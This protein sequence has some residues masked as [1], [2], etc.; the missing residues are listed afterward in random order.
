[1][2][3]DSWLIATWSGMRRV[4]GGGERGEEGLDGIRSGQEADVK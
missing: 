3:A 2:L 4:A 1:V